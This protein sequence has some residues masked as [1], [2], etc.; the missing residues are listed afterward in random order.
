MVRMLI[1]GEG[2]TLAVPIGFRWAELCAALRQQVK[3]CV[4]QLEGDARRGP[5]VFRCNPAL[6]RAAK[7]ALRDL[8]MTVYEDKLLKPEEWL[9]V[10]KESNDVAMKVTD[11]PGTV[12]RA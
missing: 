10:D 3:Q 6:V 1:G 8:N 12:T 7:D 5:W 2:R 11:Y 9:V 4:Q